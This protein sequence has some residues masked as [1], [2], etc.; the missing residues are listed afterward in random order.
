MVGRDLI[1]YILENNLE[2]EQV[3]K[4]GKILGLMTVG[5]YAEKHNVGVATVLTW[6]NQGCMEYIIV[7]NTIFIPVIQNRKGGCKFE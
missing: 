4:D 1:V 3:F 7:G 2:N 5:E 6:I